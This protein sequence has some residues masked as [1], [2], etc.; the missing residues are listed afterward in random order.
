MDKIKVRKKGTTPASANESKIKVRLKQSYIDDLSRKNEESIDRLNDYIN[1]SQIGEYMTSDELNTYRKAINDYADTYKRLSASGI[2]NDTNKW[3]N[4]LRTSVD[5]NSKT[6]SQFKNA[7]EYGAAVRDSTYRQK[8]Q[9]K[10][11]AQLQNE[12]NSLRYSR[13]GA[14]LETDKALADEIEW[15]K[16][17]TVTDRDVIGTMTDAEYSEYKTGVGKSENPE[18]D[19]LYDKLAENLNSYN[20]YKDYVKDGTTYTAESALTPDE[21]KPYEKYGIDLNRD[22]KEV[23]A[24]LD[25]LRGGVQSENDVVDYW[26]EEIKKEKTKAANKEKLKA[27]DEYWETLD[28]FDSELTYEKLDLPENIGDLS[29]EQLSA[30]SGMVDYVI[31]YNDKKQKWAIDADDNIAEEWNK[32]LQEFFDIEYNSPSFDS[33]YSNGITKEDLEHLDYGERSKLIYFYNTDPKKALEYLDAL[34]PFLKDKEDWE[35]YEN[36]KKMTKDLPV[37]GPIFGTAASVQMAPIVGVEGIGNLVKG[38]TGQELHT[39]FSDQQKLMRE[40]IS[41]DF[42]AVGKGAYTVLTNIGDVVVNTL[43]TKG[44]LSLGSL[45]TSGAGTLSSA[46]SASN[47]AS[48]V[49]NL[50]KAQQ[51]VRDTNTLTRILMAGSTVTPTMQDAIDRGLSNDK[52][53]AL[54]LSS[55]LAEYITEAIGV[56]SFLADPKSALLYLAKNAGAEGLE[57]G[58]A[59]GINTIADAVI[60]GGESQINRRIEQLMATEGVSEKEA[61]TKAWTEWAENLGYETLLGSISGGIFGLGGSIAYAQDNKITKTIGRAVK[62]NND[63]LGELIKVAELM[64]ENTEVAKALKAVEK[65]N[66]KFNIGTLSREVM[67]AINKEFS[68]VDSVIELD[69]LKSKYGNSNIVTRAYDA[70]YKRITGYTVR[71]TAKP[72]QD[73]YSGTVGNLVYK[74]ITKDGTD[75]EVKGIDVVSGDI[76]TDKGNYAAEEIAFADNATAALFENATKYNTPAVADLYVAAY[77]PNLKGVG[78]YNNAFEGIYEAAEIGKDFDYAWNTFKGY[79]ALDMAAAKAIWQAGYDKYTTDQSRRDAKLGGNTTIAETP[80]KKAKS[81]GEVRFRNGVTADTAEQK[82]AVKLAK[83]IAKIIGI[84]IEFFDSRVDKNVNGWFNRKT[85]TIHLDMQKAV[86]DRHTIAFTLSHELVHFIEKWS[87][88]KYETFA[89]FLLEKY[90]E[91]GMDLNAMLIRK[92][93]ELEANNGGKRVSVDEA[94]SELIADSCEAF[95]LDSNATEVIAELATKDKD[96]AARIKRFFADILNKLRRVYKGLNPQSEEGKLMR[97]MASECEAIYRMFE[98]ALAGAVEN[99]QNAEVVEGVSIKENTTD[100]AEA[101]IQPT[102]SM[103][104]NQAKKNDR[105][106]DYDKPI[107][108]ED[109]K[110][111]R[112]IIAAHNGERVSINDFTAEDIEKAQK[113]AYKFYKELGVK[114]PFFRAWFGDWRAYDADDAIYRLKTPLLELTN[115]KSA[116]EYIKNGIKNSSLFRGDVKNKDTDFVVNVGRQVYEDTLTYANRALSRSKDFEEYLVRLSILDKISD[117]VEYSVLL[118]T[119]V[120]SK[121]EDSSNNNSKKNINPYQSFFHRFY[122]VANVDGE[123]YLVKLTVDELNTVNTSRR[124]YN[125]NDIKISPIAVSQVYKPAGTMDENGDI[126]SAIS[127]SD[128]FNF[129]KT[130]DPEFNPH[131]VH[132]SMIDNG[133]PKVFYHGSPAQFTAF[134]KRKAKSSGYYGKGFYFSDSQ[135]HAGTYGNTYSVYLNIK[136]PLKQGETTITRE[137]VIKYLEAVAENE[138]YSIENYGTYDIDSI[139]DIV[140]GSETNKDA[141]TVIQDINATAIGD[142][143]EAAKLFNEIN[144]TSFDGIIVP[145]ETV[146]F[147]PEQIKSATKGGELDNIGTFSRYDAD[148]QFQRK[149]PT[150]DS[151]GNALSS[152]QQEY[153]KDSK[154]RDADG[155][156]RVVYHGTPNGTFTEF[157]MTEG[158]HSSLMAQYGAG[159]YFDTD[160][161]SAARYTEAVNKTGGVTNR[162]VYEVYLNITNPLE[163]TDTSRVVSKEQLAEVIRK[164][165]YEWFFTNGMPNELRNYLGKSKAEIQQL[166]REKIIDHWVDMTYERANFDSDVLSS[167]VKAFKGRAVVEAMRDVFG[168]DG[169]RVTDR[170]GEMWIA[171]DAN[172]IKQTDNLNPTSDPDIRFQQKLPSDRAILADALESVSTTNEKDADIIRRYKAQMDTITKAETRLAEVNAEIKELSFAKGKR[173]TNRLALLHKEKTALTKKVNDFDKRLLRMEST[174]VLKNVLDREKS[175]VRA[176]ANAKAKEKLNEVRQK[177]RDRAS[178]READLKAK[179]SDKLSAAKEKAEQRETAIRQKFREAQ[180]KGRENR[181]KSELRSKIKKFKTKLENIMLNPT[182]RV[183]VP[184]GLYSA[185]MDV[186]DLIDTNTELYK[187][188]GSINKA[189]EKRNLTR[190]KLLALEDEYKK[191]KNE[192]DAISEE[193][194]PVIAEY[195]EDIRQKYADK[196]LKEMTLG[197]LDDLYNNLVSIQEVLTDARKLI[198]LTDAA[199]IYEAADSIAEEQKAIQKRRKKG[200]RGA[201]QKAKDFVAI[202]S[203]SPMRAVERMADYNEASYLLKLFK[204]LEKG[205]RAKKFF[206]MNAY[207]SFEA[208][209]KGENAVN[210]EKSL[211]NN[212]GNAL[213]DK[214]GK[215]FYITKMQAMQALM[216]Y[217]REVANQKTKHVEIDGFSFADVDKIRDGKM[218]ESI[219]NEYIHKIDGIKAL[220]LVKQIEESLKNDKWAQEYMSVAREFFDNM[221]KNAVNETMLKLKHRLVAREFK[222]IPFEVDPDYIVKEISGEFDIQQTINGYGM[223]KETQRNAAQ[224]LVITGLNNIIDRH[225][226]QVGNIYGLAIPIRDFN[227]VWNTR[228]NGTP[229]NV[230]IGETWGDLKQEGKVRSGKDLI[231]QTIKDL[232]SKR[233]N[234]TD[235]LLEWIKSNYVEATF[236]MN[237][238]VISKQVASMYAARSMIEHRSWARMLGNL[239][240][241]IANYKKLSAEVDKYTATVWLRRQGVSDTE[242]ETLL[243]QKQK[244]VV[245]KFVSKI[246]VFNKFPKLIAAMDSAVALSLWKYCKADVKK[247]TGLTGEELNQATAKY[248]EEVVENTQSMAD[249]LHRPE[250]Q[251]QGGIVGESFGMFKTDLYQQAGLLQTALGRYMKNKNNNNAKALAK[252]AWGCLSSSVWTVIVTGVVALFRYKVDPYRDDEDEELTVESWLKQ[253]GYNLLGE[254]GGY[255]MPLGGGELV[256]LVN[257]VRGKSDDELFNSLALDVIED[258]ITAVTKLADVAGELITEGELPSLGDVDEILSKILTMFRVPY[259][260]ASRATKAFINHLTDIK[261]GEFLEYNVGKKSASGGVVKK[262]IN[263]IDD[264]ETKEAK[265]YLAEALADEAERKA[266]EDGY[267][268][269]SEYYLKKYEGEAKSTIKKAISKELKPLYLE[270]L[271]VKD[272]AATKRIRNIMAASQL[273]DNIEDTFIEWRKDEVSG[274]FKDRYLDAYARKDYKEMEKVI[275]EMA[276]TGLWKKPMSAV[277]TWITNYE[278]GA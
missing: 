40:I 139:V 49:G 140:M 63:A 221:A 260:N 121:R 24:E 203:L 174:E 223:L 20:L 253:S 272:K 155:N 173:D 37:Y 211:Y 6:M 191:L 150:T 185:M 179:A 76:I 232:Q 231:A 84:D 255:V 1:R 72:T 208:V 156:L 29:A 130:Y 238:S 274:D 161:K 256:S 227:K 56:E 181:A 57:E 83:Q 214:N 81:K 244:G 35:N 250:I 192:S 234:R 51:L 126:F 2:S 102:D 195:L 109:V 92:Q 183:Y 94:Y 8:Y 47:A 152:G 131:P 162:K 73:S 95:L 186:C 277:Q 113:W 266:G 267:T 79:E 118:D 7:D 14:D 46:I 119:E 70:N 239:A 141:F 74:G 53:V 15:L 226:E 128:L 201:V 61:F 33:D 36:T 153:F 262:F 166:P 261:N 77:N 3:L 43:V 124:A 197:E 165:N 278:K 175:K 100:K 129:V 88:A 160:R 249:V 78:I 182:E 54:G 257:R 101:A 188:D 18:I 204:E 164:G 26:R 115:Q 28:T 31:A 116:T 159:F 259:N 138:D 11:Y 154:V 242:L 25:E 110:L 217:E 106:A 212:F 22:L 91:K 189:Q 235:G 145:T 90:A 87:L 207:K 264:G 158:S 273:Y 68:S 147:E 135:S 30:L 209:T 210:Y 12:L 230:I 233:K 144:G 103:V 58:L 172:Q 82:N 219:S 190:D 196:S 112:S 202:K 263:L 136:E 85:D 122:T 5:N 86:D 193:Y 41:E 151:K 177:E 252:A 42:G 198:G 114:S 107:T 194:D 71:E 60:S 89:N 108:M 167:M 229:I 251:K 19:A 236:F 142:M 157:K 258:G 55:F 247:A 245:G 146:A 213:T 32:G 148:I 225:I 215:T 220:E 98:D 62:T 38:A 270:A 125:L 50:Q 178:A 132:E 200:E 9:G 69:S 265:S 184:A 52:V 176:A 93:L 45:A 246:P 21:R 127:I 48:T 206:I 228:S 80:T 163:I 243:T 117:I 275:K 97:K 44:L 105:F 64:P 39:D 27:F 218:G 67:S 66:S 240:Y 271:T 123:F 222:Y 143:V 170:Y 205:D 169:I 168:K 75:V 254:L 268:G 241:T 111:L 59:N 248:F 120:S 133:Q 96:L 34:K 137:Q 10:T 99:Y 224:P 65:K 187:A 149:L 180:E 23:M 16:N 199:D 13:R 134:D 216:S 104:Q 269:D 4:E 17:Y 276:A 171:W 237:F